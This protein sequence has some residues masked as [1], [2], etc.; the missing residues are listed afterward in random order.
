[1]IAG[2]IDFYDVAGTFD[3]WPQ[4]VRGNA[5]DRDPRQPTC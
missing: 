3:F 2:V 1:V 5:L 4:E